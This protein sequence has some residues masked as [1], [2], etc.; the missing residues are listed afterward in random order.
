MNGGLAT[1]VLAE[2]ERLSADDKNLLSTGFKNHYG[3]QIS[4]SLDEL[5]EMDQKKLET[6]KSIIDGI[7]LT[8]EHVP[9]ILTVYARLKDKDLPSRISFG[10]LNQSTNDED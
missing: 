3:K 5:S 2:F 8:R 7:H 10:R 6:I 9:N 1:E 4:F